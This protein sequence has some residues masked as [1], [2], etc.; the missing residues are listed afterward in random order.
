MKVRVNVINS[1][2]DI[3]KMKL[4]I[5]K[6]NKD[7]SAIIEKKMQL[8]NKFVLKIYILIMAIL[9][10]VIFSFLDN[11]YFIVIYYYFDSLIIS[12]SNTRQR[13]MNNLFIIS[14]KKK[15]KG[16]K[17]RTQN[18]VHFLRGWMQITTEKKIEK[19]VI[20]F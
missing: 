6:K 4:K 2:H 15:K 18:R 7:S 14:R 13:W 8:I 5:L 16:W 9:N 12:L 11:R 20:I 3:S 10:S 17:A 1:K 19:N